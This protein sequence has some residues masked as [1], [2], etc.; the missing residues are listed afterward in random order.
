MS[1]G[2]RWL[3]DTEQES[4]KTFQLMQMQLNA[5]LNRQLARD[6]GI[7][8]ADY[9]VLVAL[10]EERDGRMRAYELGGAL[11]WEKS[12]LSHHV[13]RMANR[14]LVDRDGCPSDRRGAYVVVTEK[15]REAIRAAAPGHVDAVR[16][17]FVDLLTAEQLEAMGTIA[18]V[19]LRELAGECDP[20]EEPAGA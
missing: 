14:G 19:V 1:D 2:H 5:A 8:L 9:S 17:R 7:S 12:R 13:T 6:S 11:G 18:G 20:L 3:S 4:W 15:G 10:T 16:A